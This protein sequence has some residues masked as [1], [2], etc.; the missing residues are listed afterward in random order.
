MVVST[1]A[2][3]NLRLIQFR[4]MTPSATFTKSYSA[5]DMAT[6]GQLT[7]SHLTAVLDAKSTP[8]GISI[9]SGPHFR[10]SAVDLW[11]DE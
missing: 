8:G 7:L 4:I 6:Y 1:D 10:C 11:V 3:R 2:I 9:T 5:A